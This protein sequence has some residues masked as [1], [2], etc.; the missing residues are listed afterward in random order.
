MDWNG[1]GLR[2]VRNVRVEQ[3]P[4]LHRNDGQWGRRKP[5]EGFPRRQE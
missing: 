5:E 1:L 3:T 2:N 4:Q